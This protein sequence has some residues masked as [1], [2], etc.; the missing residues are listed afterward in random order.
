MST[1]AQVDMTHRNKKTY[2]FWIYR[3]GY[4]TGVVPDLPDEEMD[5][6][7]VR[8]ALRLGDAPESMPDYYY[9]ISLADRT[10][11]IYDADFES[12]P[13]KRGKLLFSGTFADAKQTFK[14]S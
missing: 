5:F 14:D 1:R 12:K 3:D 6:E 11:E 2:R 8:R 4:P 7:D 9:T 10:I 13:W